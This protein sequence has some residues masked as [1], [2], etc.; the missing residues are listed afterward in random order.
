MTRS[1]GNRH[2]TSVI[3]GP[4]LPYSTYVVDG[5]QTS[6]PQRP[7]ESKESGRDAVE[8]GRGSSFT[9]KRPTY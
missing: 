2:F 8:G 4:N 6:V 5:R 9:R 7:S 3:V 1:Q